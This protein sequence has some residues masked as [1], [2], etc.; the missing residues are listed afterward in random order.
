MNPR[1]SLAE[2]GRTIGHNEMK[3][4]TP[5]GRPSGRCLLDYA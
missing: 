4:T 5:R 3:T 2:A 1:M